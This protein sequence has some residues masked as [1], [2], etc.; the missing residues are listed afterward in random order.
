MEN[1]LS[2]QNKLINFFRLIRNLMSKHYASY[3]RVSF[4]IYLSEPCI[5][6]HYIFDTKTETVLALIK[7]QNFSPLLV[8]LAGWYLRLGF[9]VSLNG[10]CSTSDEVCPSSIS[11]G[12]MGIQPIGCW[13]TRLAASIWQTCLRLA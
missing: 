13:F 8:L 12:P 4:Q 6:P 10:P 7:F 2:I 5:T 9:F 11:L 1:I 3:S